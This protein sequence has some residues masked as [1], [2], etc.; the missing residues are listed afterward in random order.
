MPQ[1]LVKFLVINENFQL[2]QVIL[3]GG[4]VGDNEVAIKLFENLNIEGKNI[5]SQKWFQ[6]FANLPQVLEKFMEIE[7]RKWR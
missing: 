5:F 7:R 3:S 4:Q 1:V 6:H 2:L